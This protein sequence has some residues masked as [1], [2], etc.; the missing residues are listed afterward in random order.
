MNRSCIGKPSLLSP[1]AMEIVSASW[2]DDA[3]EP[4]RL[5]RHASGQVRR[6]SAE[7]NSTHKPLVDF[8]VSMLPFRSASGD[9]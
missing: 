6:P 5:L 9:I 3:V 7:T 8:D 2:V 1:V 4:R